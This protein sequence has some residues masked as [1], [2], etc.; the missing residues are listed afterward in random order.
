MWASKKRLDPF[1][2][3]SMQDAMVAT[4]R[5]SLD[6]YLYAGFSRLYGLLPLS[7]SS[8]WLAA[9]HGLALSGLPSQGGAMIR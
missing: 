9:M 2:V 7:R 3:P 5:S 4:H 6:L 1:F 8:C